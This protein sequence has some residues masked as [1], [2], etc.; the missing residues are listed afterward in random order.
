MKLLPARRRFLLLFAIERAEPRTR[1]YRARCRRHLARIT[2]DIAERY[3]LE[4]M[5][6]ATSGTEQINRHWRSA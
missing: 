2:R 1:I 6:D 5:A 3:Q 4:Q